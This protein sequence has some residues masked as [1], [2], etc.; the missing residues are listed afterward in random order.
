V[1]E[2]AICTS[3]LHEVERVLREHGGHRVVSIV[4]RVGP[5][6]GVEPGLLER[7]YSVA[8]AGSCA[9]G[10]ALVL[11][12]APVRVRCRECDSCA[13]VKNN[14]LTCPRC[15]SWRTELMSGDELLLARV[16]L[17]RVTEVEA[18]THV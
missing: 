9:Q 8:S 18:G 7:A 12:D 5:L 4:V 1:H 3:L 17:E 2:L 15:G 10:A 11:E 13:G 6:S 16:E 14:D